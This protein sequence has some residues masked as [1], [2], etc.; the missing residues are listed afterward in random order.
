MDQFMKEIGLMIL[1]LEMVYMFGVM[2]ENMKGNGQIIACMD[3]EF[4]LGQM[5]KNIK[6]I[7]LRIKKRDMVNIRG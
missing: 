3:K 4:I 6:E 5:G 2:E 1:Y 7:I